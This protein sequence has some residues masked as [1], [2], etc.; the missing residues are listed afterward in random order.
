LVVEGSPRRGRGAPGKD[1]LWRRQWG[2]VK[3]GRGGGAG[4][5]FRSARFSRCG[6]G[7]VVHRARGGGGSVGSRFG[8]VPG[9]DP[10]RTLARMAMETPPSSRD[11]CFV[12]SLHA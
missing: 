5:D 6:M 7:G 9:F 10:H 11:P 3:P 1:N 4:A 12:E 2:S 8:S